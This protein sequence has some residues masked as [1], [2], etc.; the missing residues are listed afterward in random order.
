MLNRWSFFHEVFKGDDVS[1][2]AQ[3]FERRGGASVFPLSLSSSLVNSMSRD[4]CS[5]SVG[6][7]A[8]LHPFNRIYWVS[9]VPRTVHW[10]LSCWVCLGVCSA[11]CPGRNLWPPC[12]CS[13]PAPLS[14]ISSPS[15]QKQREPFPCNHSPDSSVRRE[16]LRKIQIT[17]VMGGWHNTWCFVHGLAECFTL[18]KIARKPIISPLAATFKSSYK[19]ALTQR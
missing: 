4:P 1:H 15:L 8:A 11:W 13:S 9:S 7:S 2:R 18:H 14:D 16:T 6:S 3:H 17:L 5:D 19:T 10:V 12:S